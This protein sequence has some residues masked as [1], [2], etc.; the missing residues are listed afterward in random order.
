M[1]RWLRRSCGPRNAYSCGMA[2]IGSIADSRQQ[3]G[4]SFRM[5]TCPVARLRFEI[6]AEFDLR[7]PT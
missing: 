5:V 7:S 2:S 4:Y 3:E 6:R 1:S